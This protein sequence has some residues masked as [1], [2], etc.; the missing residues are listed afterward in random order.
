MHSL[1]VPIVVLALT[2]SSA[3]AEPPQWIGKGRPMIETQRLDGNG[4]WV[5]IGKK[6]RASQRWILSVDRDDDGKLHGSVAIADSPLARSGVVRG[7][8]RGRHVS[9]TIAD[10]RGRHIAEFRG[11]ASADGVRGTYTDRTGETG[12]WVWDGPLPE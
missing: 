7:S 12:D 11:V 5:P 1:L 3:A 9:G 2:S 6:R 4:S 8:M 10:S